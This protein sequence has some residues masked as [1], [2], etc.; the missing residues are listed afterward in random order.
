MRKALHTRNI[1]SFG[2]ELLNSKFQSGRRAVRVLSECEVLSPIELTLIALECLDDGLV[3]PGVNEKPAVLFLASNILIWSTL[4]SPVHPRH[5]AEA[6]TSM[7]LALTPVLIK[8]AE[9]EVN[10]SDEC[11]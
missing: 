4:L 1:T 2:I 7:A 3:H 10:P 8:S 5:H 9:N 11:R 6:M